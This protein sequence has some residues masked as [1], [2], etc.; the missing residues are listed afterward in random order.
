MVSF[1]SNCIFKVMNQGANRNVQDAMCHVVMLPWCILLT[2]YILHATCFLLLLLGKQTKESK[3]ANLRG[4][5]Y[6]RFSQFLLA[7]H[8]P[9]LFTS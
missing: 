4:N 8:S 1:F 9:E 2:F 6:L 5:F 7:L 3:N